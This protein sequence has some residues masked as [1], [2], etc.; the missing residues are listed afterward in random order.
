M[1]R[2][3]GAYLFSDTGTR[4][5]DFSSGIAVT[6]LGHG[7]P[8]LVKALK[9]QAETLWHVSNLFRIP[10]QEALAARLVARTFADKVFFCNSGV[11]AW[12]AGV[13]AVRRYHHQRGAPQKNR[14]ITVQGGFHGR[15]IS[16][17]SATRGAKSIEGFA[18]L[19]DGYDPVPFGSITA[20]REAIT[21]ETAGICL[22][23][24]L[25]EGGIRP[26]STEYL[27]AIRAICDEFEL[28]LFLDEVQSGNGR[29][30]KFFC[31][32]WAGIEP[33]LVCTAKGMGGGFPV[34]AL[35]LT[36]AVAAA[37]TPGTHGTTYG[38]NPLAMAVA[39]AVLDVIEEPGFLEHVVA[40][41]ARL[42]AGLMQLRDRYPHMIAEVRGLGLLR[43]I[44][45]AEP[46][47][48]GDFVATARA[49]GL[50]CVGASDNAVR[51]APPL[52]VAS[53]EVDAA[54]EVLAATAATLAAS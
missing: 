49:H 40:M 8:H 11:E 54:L 52:I 1:V 13:K 17:I 37:M 14:I 10:G 43:G 12:E 7:H 16:A 47:A 45:L 28:L 51:L 23:P 29:T 5:L 20:L 46:W 41:G 3:E 25:G 30:G 9:E 21:T 50:L 24:I 32:E 35:L 33:D 6:S 2:G 36:D 42:E 15:T 19:A 27:Q 38:G 53:A 44:K 48:S 22:E 4:Y 31:Y 26:A 39:G 34:G 18:P